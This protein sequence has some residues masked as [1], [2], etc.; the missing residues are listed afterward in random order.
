[1]ATLDAAYVGRLISMTSQA[2]FVRSRSRKL[3]G[4]YN[5]IGRQGLDM[6]TGG[7]VAP[8]TCMILTAACFVEIDGLVRIFLECVEDIFMAALADIRADI[9]LRSGLSR[10]RHNPK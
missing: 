4:I 10:S 5:I 6:R 1:M 2:R 7:T 8:L 3:C 9:S